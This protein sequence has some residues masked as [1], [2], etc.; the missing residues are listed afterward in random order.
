MQSRSHYEA[1]RHQSEGPSVEH[2]G[3]VSLEAARCAPVGLQDISRDRSALGRKEVLLASEHNMYMYMAEATIREASD[4][5]KGSGKG[6]LSLRIGLTMRYPPI[7][8]VTTMPMATAT[9]ALPKT[10]LTT[11]GIVEKNAPLAAPLIT[12][13][14]IS[15]ASVVEAGQTANMVTAVSSKDTSKVLR[16]P[17]LSQAIPDKIR[18]NADDRLNPATRLAPTLE[19]NP[20]DRAYEGMKKGGT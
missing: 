7:Q 1:C 12:T 4:P 13:K 5:S 9:R 20:I 17:S 15:G 8:P 18:P 19:E 10:L 6:A 2:G 3:V 11:V 16:D 14:A